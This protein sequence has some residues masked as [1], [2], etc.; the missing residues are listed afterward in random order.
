MFLRSYKRKKNG[1]WHEYFSV[2]ENRRVAGGS[3]VQR[4][5]LYLGEITSSQENAWQKTLEVFDADSGKYE[6]K[7]VYFLRLFEPEAILRQAGLPENY[8]SRPLSKE[9]PACR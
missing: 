1:K 4:T 9:S 6:Q 5:V 8:P 2:I 3:T 7:L